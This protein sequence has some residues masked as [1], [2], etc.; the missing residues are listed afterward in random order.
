MPQKFSLPICLLPTT[1]S[2]T[3]LKVSKLSSCPFRPWQPLLPTRPAFHTSRLA[4]LLLFYKPHPLLP[5]LSPKLAPLFLSM[6]ISPW[7]M[8]NQALTVVSQPCF[9]RIPMFSSLSNLS[10]GSSLANSPKVITEKTLNL[11]GH[12]WM[13]FKSI[14][15]LWISI[16]FQCGSF[17]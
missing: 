17:R 16:P 9:S 3:P 4:P 14:F 7:M 8:H 6:L 12:P 11:E 5:L 2:T 10:I 1:N 13:F 15:A